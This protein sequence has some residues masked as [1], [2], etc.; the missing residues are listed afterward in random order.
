MNDRN[1]LKAG[2]LA[3]YDT[4][5]GLVPCKVVRVI[6]TWKEDCPTCIS[7]LVIHGKPVKARAQYVNNQICPQ[8][9]GSGY[10]IP[11][12]IRFELSRGGVSSRYKVDVR[13]TATRCAY[14]K[15]EVLK[16]LFAHDVVPR[17]A[18]RFRQ[19]SAMITKYE[20]EA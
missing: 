14:K 13:L 5:S 6:D 18:V 12:K 19:Y 3:F 11:E 15:G 7:T 17:Q 9:N 10:Y 16:D 1:V 20:V 2:S 4:F 8:C